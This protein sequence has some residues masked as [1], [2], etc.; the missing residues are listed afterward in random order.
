MKDA[1][2][3]PMMVVWDNLAM[4]EVFT[5]IARQGGAPYIEL[6]WFLNGAAGGLWAAAD[7]FNKKV[8]DGD[9]RLGQHDSATPW[10]DDN[11]PLV[12]QLRHGAVHF[13]QEQG[14]GRAVEHV[15]GTEPKLFKYVWF[16]C[17]FD[18]NKNEVIPINETLLR[19]DVVR[20]HI[21]EHVSTISGQGKFPVHLPSGRLVEADDASLTGD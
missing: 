8:A 13:R 21:E 9:E 18:G 15:A 6:E 7:I 3:E 5:H 1:W 4:A 10:F 14:V 2:F 20:S 19:L 16:G 12:N 11:E 17:D